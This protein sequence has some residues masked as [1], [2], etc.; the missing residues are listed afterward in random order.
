MSSLH[1]HTG[2]SSTRCRSISPNSL[3]VH[4]WTSNTQCG[5][6]S[7]NRLLV[8]EYHSMEACAQVPFMC[9]QG[10]QA[11]GVEAYPPTLFMYTHG[12]QVQYGR[13]SMSSF[14][15]HTGTSST[16]LKHIYELPSCAHRDIKHSVEAYLSAPSLC[17][18]W[19]QADYDRQTILVS[20][21]NCRESIILAAAKCFLSAFM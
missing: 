11:H 3:H 18:Q 19:H 15:V 6:M 21:K 13:M 12:H 5:S 17:T 10:H 14:H 7:P 2:T 4:T 9:P 20:D 16:V 8:Q 1:V